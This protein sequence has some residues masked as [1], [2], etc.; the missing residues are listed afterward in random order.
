MAVSEDIQKQ[1]L[2]EATS[3]TPNFEIDYNDERFANLQKDNEQTLN[4]IDQTYGGMINSANKYYDDL[5]QNAQDWADKQSQLQQERTDFAIEQIEQQKEQAN[6]DYLKEQSG[7]YVDWQKQSNQYGV[8]AEKMAA[9]GLDKTG[10]SESSQVS[11]Y[12]TYQNRVST[13]RESYNQAVLNYNNAIKDAQ[14]Q[15][16]AT[17]AE[18]AYNALQQQLEL[19]LE[20]FQYKNQLILE[21]T[22]KKIEL[23]NTLWQQQMDIIDQMNTE[24]AMKWDVTKYYD[25]QAWETEQAEINRQ[26]DITLQKL[27]QEFD[28]K[29]NQLNRDFQAKQDELDRKHEFELLN[30]KTEKEKELANQQHQLEMQKLAK[31]QE[32]EM[33]QLEKEKQ[34]KIAI[35]NQELAN[36][37]ALA[38]HEASLSAKYSD[39]SGGGAAIISDST[40]YSAPIG[41]PN[42]VSTAYYQGAKNKDCQ[43][44]TFSNGYQPDNINGQKLTKTGETTT[45]KTSIKY[46]DNKGQKVSV[47]QNIWKTPDGKKWIW[48]GVNNKYV[49]A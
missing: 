9:A 46:G 29:E 17:L 6:K 47:T 41:S 10:F 36:A 11:M 37:K 27:Q 5:A 26:H 39:S 33:A 13:A 18:I 32:Y 22:N 42:Q 12:N 20:G 30:A 43:Y 14:L 48:D 28:A 49:P 8:E 25:T 3:A 45:V 1:M 15:N 7:A 38:T 31:Q 2:A 4:E 21:Q 35:A 19:S 34:N 23:K 24:N 16:N 44:G 40:Q